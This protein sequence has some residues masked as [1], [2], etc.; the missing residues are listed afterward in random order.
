ML[1]ETVNYYLQ[2]GN[3]VV[4][5]ALDLSKTHEKVKHYRLF[6]KQLQ[7]GVPVSVVRLLATW[8]SSQTMEVKWKNRTS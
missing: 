8:Y 7:K 6:S 3:K 2:N 5:C 4:Y 1:K